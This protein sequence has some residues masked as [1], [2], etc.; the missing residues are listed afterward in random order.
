MRESLFSQ[1]KYFIA[2][3]GMR[4]HFH[5]SKLNVHIGEIIY[6]QTDT[7]KNLVIAGT[8]Q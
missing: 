5:I 2:L 4:W 3:Y 6:F 8:M 7:G 1:S